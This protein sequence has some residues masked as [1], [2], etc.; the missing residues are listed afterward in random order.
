MATLKGRR[1]AMDATATISTNIRRLRGA[2]DLSQERLASLAGLSR[3]AYRKIETGQSQ[4]RVSTLQSIARALDVRVHELVESAPEF[5][6]VRFRSKKRLRTR[7]QILVDAS[8]WLRDFNE[9]EDLLEDRVPWRLAAVARDLGA[10]AARPAAAAARVR[11]EFGIRPDEPVRDLCGLLEANGVKVFPMEVASHDFFG[12]SVAPEDGGP[13]VVV[14]TWERISVER[15][16]FTAAHELG[17]LVLHLGTYD[18]DETDEPDDQEQEANAF[19]AAFLMPDGV[20]WK[21]W[22][23]TYGL[24]LVDRVLKVKRMFRVSY[25]TVLFRL[26]QREAVAG[27]IWAKFQWD[28]KRR[29]GRPLLRDDEP[30]A[31]AADAFRASFPED[32][33]AGEPERLSPVDF[34]E[35]RLSRLVRRAV[36]DEQISLGRGAEILGLSLKEMRDLA[37]A[38]VA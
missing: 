12:L 19:A 37:A 27:N 17:H 23:E 33:R 30:D 28:Y 31:L 15:W 2:R 35:D 25:R 20:F 10:R 29:F 11:E 36:E 1:I 13:A 3:A 38:W 9:L 4:P 26:S 32:R 6:A 34:E 24:G 5:K 22:D 8:R 14:N 7:E 21:E 18:V 16:I